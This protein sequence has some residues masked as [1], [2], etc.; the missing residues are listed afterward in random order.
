[1]K[2]ADQVDGSSFTARALSVV[3]ATGPWSNDLAPAETSPR[4]RPSRGAHIVVPATRLKL[5]AA[6][7]MQS[8]A[9]GRIT[10]AIPWNGHTYIGTT[11]SEDVDSPDSVRIRPRDVAYLI[12]VA[13]HYFPGADLTVDDV[14]SAWV[15]VR[16]LVASRAGHPSEIPRTHQVVKH[17]EGF[18]TVYGGKLT[19]YRLMARDVLAGL[20]GVLGP[21][22][23]RGGCG[24]DLRPLPGGIDFPRRPEDETMLNERLARDF[25]V[26]REVI[27]DLLQRH[28]RGA[29]FI[30]NRLREYPADAE[31]LV[32]G[33]PY[34]RAELAYSLDFECVVRPEDFLVRRTSILHR[35][36]DRGRAVLEEVMGVMET[37]GWMTDFDKRRERGRHAELASF[38]GP[39]D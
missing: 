37:R 5:S 28:G 24:T 2:L 15:G 4:L 39:G 16:P 19:T 9:D 38:I 31:V 10:F 18:V 30:L 33:L 25:G 34:L 11:E 27:G 32:A 23:G 36:P 6:V 22:A 26:S 20:A 1:L 35:A 13:R 12:D 29:I 17:G 8:P 14:C 21:R 7:V 3:N